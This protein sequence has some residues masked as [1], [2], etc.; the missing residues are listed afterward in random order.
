MGV[1]LRTNSQ[2]IGTAKTKAL[3][4]LSYI[5]KSSLKIRCFHL[6][7]FAKNRKSFAVSSNLPTLHKLDI[8]GHFC[9]HRV[10]LLRKLS[11]SDKI[12]IIA[13][14]LL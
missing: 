6:I 1:G 2:F 10:D 3:R 12:A 7:Q 13:I 14:L 4:P 8:I 5:P 9:G 11:H